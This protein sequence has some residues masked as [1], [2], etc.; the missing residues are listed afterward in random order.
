MRSKLKLP[1]ATTAE[2]VYVYAAVEGTP[3]A[4]PQAGMPG[5]AAPH[6]VPLSDGIALIVSRVPAAAYDAPAIEGRLT[7]LDWVASAGAAHHAVIDAVA[8]AGVETLPFRLFTIF[9]TE[10]R[11]REAFSERLPAILRGFDRVRGR[12]EWV[13]R[14]GKPDPSRATAPAQVTPATSG[15][16]FLAAKAAAR[17]DDAARTARVQRDAAAAYEAL[18]R[19]AD[20]ARLKEVDPS[21]NLLIDAALLVSPRAEE[22]LK[23]TLTASAAQLLDDGCAV[24]LTGPWP[25]Y[26]FASL[27]NT[28]NG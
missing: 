13:L 28:T 27:D 1:K 11:A 23:R 4:L 21:G 24:S 16:S 19:L 7:D 2:H 6:T 5:G 26:S 15:T 10:A 9:S 3:T 20:G 25:P 17:R 18:A 14:I 12:R 22:N 8:D